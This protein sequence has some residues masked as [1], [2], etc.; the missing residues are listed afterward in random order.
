MFSYTYACLNDSAMNVICVITPPVLVVSIS[1]MQD[2]GTALMK[3][4][5]YGY[6]ACVDI[7]IKAGADV[8]A[9]D[10]VR[11]GHTCKLGRPRGPCAAH[12]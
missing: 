1:T 8:N 6:S 3:A 4:A 2:G 12:T 9:K 11:T 7:I 5:Q 10:E